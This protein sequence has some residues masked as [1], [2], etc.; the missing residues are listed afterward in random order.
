MAALRRV[1]ASVGAK[2]FTLAFVVLLVTLGSLGWANVRLHRRHLELE[3][4]R[5]AERLSNV[6]VRSIGYS[7]LRNDRPALRGI[8]GPSAASRR[9]CRSASPITTA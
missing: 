6:I 2:L 9:S 8:I 5:S 7:M 1:G 3:T 4:Q